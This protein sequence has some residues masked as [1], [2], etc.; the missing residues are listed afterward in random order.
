MDYYLAKANA[1]FSKICPE[2][3]FMDLVPH[4]E[5]IIYT[6]AEDTPEVKPED[7]SDKEIKEEEEKEKEKEEEEKELEKEEEK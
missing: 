4:P 6:V 1:I 7:K 5:D 2:E 3:Q